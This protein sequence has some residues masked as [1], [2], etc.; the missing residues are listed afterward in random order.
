L[1]P[2]PPARLLV[3]DAS[4]V[5]EALIGS[6]LGAV[7]RMRMRGHELHGPAHLD[8]EILSALGRLYRAG[9]LPA[10]AVTGALRELALAPIVRH[11]LA[12]L[13]DGAW[14]ARDRLRLVD[15][16]YLE[17]VAKLD[18]AL[19]TTDAKLARASETAELV[20]LP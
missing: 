7:V 17:L 12:D 16:L 3:V 6:E 19:L 11:H 9:E 8:A 14:Q 15:A 2:D 20:A 5:V 4:A 1:V 13:L 18:A 10:E